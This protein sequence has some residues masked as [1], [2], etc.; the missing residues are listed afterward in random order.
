[1]DNIEEYKRTK[2]AYIAAY[3]NLK[4]EILNILPEGYYIKGSAVYIFNN[5]LDEEEFIEIDKIV[6]LVDKHGSLTDELVKNNLR[7]NCYY[8]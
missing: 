7:Y 3:D 6:E 5:E 8:R 1:M 2:E 4:S